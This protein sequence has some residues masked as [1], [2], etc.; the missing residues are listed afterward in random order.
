MMCVLSI[1]S[2]ESDHGFVDGP[3]VFSGCRHPSEKK[4]K[5]TGVTAMAKP[6][7]QREGSLIIEALNQALSSQ[8]RSVEEERCALLEQAMHKQ[9]QAEDAHRV[10]IDRALGKIHRFKAGHKAIIDRALSN[11]NRIEAEHR[12]TLQRALS[13]TQRNGLAQVLVQV[14]NIRRAKDPGQTE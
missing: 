13:Q 9:R 7:P 12:A 6:P 8:R 3:T 1:D 11:T 14:P 4:Q 10:I 2:F 5:P